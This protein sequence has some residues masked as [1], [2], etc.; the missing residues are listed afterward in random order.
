TPMSLA[1]QGVPGCLLANH[2]VTPSRLIRLAQEHQAAADAHGHS[3]PCR[4][5]ESDPY[6]GRENF[7]PRADSLAL[8]RIGQRVASLQW[9][10]RLARHPSK[11]RYSSCPDLAKAPWAVK[12]TS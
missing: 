4:S 7:R 2:S 12:R 5:K 10:C 11:A 6:G 1:Y 3:L 8:C 9:R